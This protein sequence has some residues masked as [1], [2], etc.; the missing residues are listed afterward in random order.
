MIE[1]QRMGHVKLCSIHRSSQSNQLWH[2]VAVGKSY[3]AVNKHCVLSVFIRS[4]LGWSLPWGRFKGGLLN[5]EGLKTNQTMV[6]IFSRPSHCLLW[7]SIKM[8]KRYHQQ[9]ETRSFDLLRTFNKCMQP[10]MRP[11]YLGNDPWPLR[12]QAH[13]STYQSISLTHWH[14]CKSFSVSQTSMRED[15][16]TTMLESL[17][18]LTERKFCWARWNLI[19]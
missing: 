18:N 16:S 11:N 1:V 12:I 2:P 5:L 9:K 6:G 8:K 10:S 19:S 3:R 4:T 17:F 14:L 7:S 13:M 15:M